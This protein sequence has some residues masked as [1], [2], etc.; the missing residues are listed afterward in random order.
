MPAPADGGRRSALMDTGARVC[1]FLSDMDSTVS[2]NE[3]L[4]PHTWFGLGGA[5]RWMVQPRSIEQLCTIVRRCRQRDVP[6]RVLGLGANLLVSDD[7]VDGVVVRL[8]SPVFRTIRWGS[9]RDGRASNLKV[10]VG[11]GTDMNRLSL[12]A[13]RHGLSGLECM[14]GI[15][16][17]LGGIVR[18]NAG[19]RLG[20]IENV[21][22]NVTVVDSTGLLRTLS[23][24]DVGFQY[25]RTNLGDS[26]VVEA[27]LALSPDDPLRVRERLLQI[28]NDKKRSQPMADYSAGCVFKNPPGH[29]AGQLI[30]QAGLKGRTVGGAS[31]SRIHANFI[32]A[33]EGAT[34]RDVLTLIG[35][36]RREVAAQFGIELELEI[37][38]W[39]PRMM[40][41][42]G[43]MEQTQLA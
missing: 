18:M 19:G 37:E 42:S 34:A 21:V 24:D 43:P 14:G 40:Y 25:R 8:K 26:I 32:V 28:W 15:P 4:A 12:E 20:A 31:V 13:A 22:H 27:T 23:N 1:D 35:I 17:T 30:D 29:S 41:A 11:G 3:P 7:G 38:V 9:A 16:G 5:A 39:G 33:K 2:Q 10:I 36:I 6:W